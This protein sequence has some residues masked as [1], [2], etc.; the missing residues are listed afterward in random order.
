MKK[1]SKLALLAGVLCAALMVGC[2]SAKLSYNRDLVMAVAWQQN[3]GEYAALC[4][5]AF[6]AG[7]VHVESLTPS[8]GEKRAVVFDIDETVLDNSPYAAWQ[9]VTGSPWGTETWEAWCNAAQ[10]DAVPGALEFTRFLTSR[11]IDVFYVSNRPG[12][13][14]KTT[15]DNLERLGFPN[16]DADHVFLQ[17]TT[18]DKQPRLDKITVEGYAIVMLVGDNLDDFDSI[19]RKENNAERLGWVADKSDA[20]G[21]SR[22]VLPNPVYGTFESALAPNYYGLTPGE[23][24][25]A[26]LEAIRPWQ[27]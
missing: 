22:I 11:G 18:S 2:V 20:F 23:K 16:A 15:A 21:V 8:S 26:R 24:A 4:H 27:P 1:L 25:S 6:N 13:V 12:S 5:Q 14:L 10:A 7:R 19:L 3:S 9:V 17:Q